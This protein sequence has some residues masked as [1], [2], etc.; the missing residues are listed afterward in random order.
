MK[1][2]G[3]GLEAQER[4]SFGFVAIDI[5]M[6]GFLGELFLPCTRQRMLA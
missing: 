1:R 5:C 3:L 2:N 4:D 6:L